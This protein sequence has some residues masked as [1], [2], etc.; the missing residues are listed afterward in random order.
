M[1][2]LKT[3]RQ[4]SALDQMRSRFAAQREKRQQEGRALNEKLYTDSLLHSFP[5]EP[6]LALA[7]STVRSQVAGTPNFRGE[8]I[9]AMLVCSSGRR[10]REL[11]SL[12]PHHRPLPP[13]QVGPALE[14]FMDWTE[15]EAFAELHPIE[16][17]SLTQARLLEIAPFA[18]L[19]IPLARTMSFFWLLRAGLVFPLW[20]HPQPGKYEEYLDAAFCLEMQPLVDYILRGERE[21]LRELV[22]E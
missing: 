16:Q 6:S 7:A 15:G 5:G 10:S 14:R 12:T 20:P 3:A 8:L 13:G 9:D 1:S 4:F 17:A 2:D 18:R 22:G 19:N 11:A 21:A